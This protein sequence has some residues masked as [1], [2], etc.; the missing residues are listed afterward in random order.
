MKNAAWAVLVALALTCHWLDTARA[1]IREGADPDEL[2]P[3]G[4]GE[5]VMP[6]I[7]SMGT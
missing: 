6:K 4:K 2:L 5:P 3:S 7:P 1:F